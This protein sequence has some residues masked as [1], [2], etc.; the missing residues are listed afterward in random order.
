MKIALLWHGS[1]EAR[2]SSVPED[3]RLWPTIEAFRAEGFLVEPCV[4]NDEFADE[5]REQLEHVDAVQVWVNPITED[6]RTRVMLDGLLREM[7]DS[8]VLV[9]AHPETIQK[10]G[11]KEVLY[12]TREMGWGSDVRRYAD[13]S[14][15]ASGLPVSLEQG[16]R[17]LK[18]FRGHSGQ[19]I[20]KITPTDD[21]SR[22]RAKHA[23]R[24]SEEQEMSL[25]Q[26]VD[27]C[28]PYFA[29]GPMLD[30]EYNPRIV[31]GTVRCYLVTD[32]IEGFGHQEV[33]ALVPGTDP[34]PRLYF[35]P[36][37]PDFQELKALVET[38]WL[39]ELM[40][41]TGE[42]LEELP[43]LW[44]IDLM[45]RDGGYM[46]CEINVSSVY[47]YPESARAPMVRAFKARLLDRA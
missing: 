21:P 29:T 45:L 31:T 6:G 39:P 42:S 8:G 12:T 1:R 33:N 11:T 16:P 15:M 25:A 32:R 47:P 4:Y 24:G 23:V 19:G 3:H 46:L 43:M 2:D 20:W 30:Q 17:V 34:G 22:V 41:L 10:M 40:G 27:E 5:V 37:R 38:V 9:S 18:Q 7:T 13:A 44:D 35:P 28:S 36:D 14:E 26:W